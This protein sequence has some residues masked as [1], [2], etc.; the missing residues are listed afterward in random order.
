[1]SIWGEI[2]VSSLNLPF[3]AISRSFRFLEAWPLD[4]A[5]IPWSIK[6]DHTALPAPTG[7]GTVPL[8]YRRTNH[9]LDECKLCPHPLRCDYRPG[10]ALAPTSWTSPF[11]FP[12]RS[13]TALGQSAD[14][15]L[16]SWSVQNADHS[17]PLLGP[18][19]LLPSTWLFSCTLALLTP[20]LNWYDRKQC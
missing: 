1:M 2:P 12:T 5:H 4:C 20:E 17:L 10:R 8:P 7:S 9:H 18:L 6:V 13:I 16:L 19:G 14:H 15:L 3:L 11:A